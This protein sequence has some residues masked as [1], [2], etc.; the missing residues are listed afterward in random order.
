M[1]SL[2]QTLFLWMNAPARPDLFLLSIATL[3]AEKIIWVTP[4]ILV[5]SWLRGS[6]HARR[7]VL[8][9]SV[10][11]LL[12]LLSNQLIGLIWPHPRP[13]M[14]GIGNCF[15]P[16]VADSSFPSDHITVMCSMAFS[17]LYYRGFR[18]AGVTLAVLA[19]PVAWARIYLGVHF[20]LDMV[21]AVAVSAGASWLASGW[22]FFYMPPL[23]RLS[24]ALHRALFAPLIAVG[25]VHH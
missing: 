17:F 22:A 12:A 4:I 11:T 20:P 9:A 25:W 7:I 14:I 18:L 3:C 24:I 23:F 19:I 13:F 16:H 6:D 1:E 8:V 2:N 21:G 5:I 10:T 15:L